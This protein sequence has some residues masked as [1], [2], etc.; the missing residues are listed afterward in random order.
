MQT[1]EVGQWGHAISSLV[2]IKGWTSY[3]C[4]LCLT[5]EHPIKWVSVKDTLCKTSKVG[6]NREDCA[7]PP[8]KSDISHIGDYELHINS[9]T[10]NSLILLTLLNLFNF[11]NDINWAIRFTNIIFSWQQT[12]FRPITLLYHKIVS[13]RPISLY[14]M[15]HVQQARKHFIL[16]KLFMQKSCETTS[17]SNADSKTL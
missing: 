6:W 17:I 4:A 11:T 15:G 7:I 1:A 3:K 12:I 13:D 16:A 10:E 14:N 8:Q 9:Q 2:S 5:Q